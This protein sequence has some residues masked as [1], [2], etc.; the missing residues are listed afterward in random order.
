[1]LFFVKQKAAF[2]LTIKLTLD[3]LSSTSDASLP[4]GAAEDKVSTVTEA[5]EDSHST[6]EALFYLLHLLSLSIA[7]PH[8]SPPPL[9]HPLPVQMMS[10]FEHHRNKSAHLFFFVLLS[11]VLSRDSH[12]FLV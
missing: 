11:E 2:T 3:K 1:M 12:C 7:L 8:G 6:H 4:P 9:S 10:S 5:C